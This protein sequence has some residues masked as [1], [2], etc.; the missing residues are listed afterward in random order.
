MFEHSPA[1]VNPQEFAKRASLY[2]VLM[3]KELVVQKQ[4]N[5]L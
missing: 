2:W 5:Q 1:E 4:G 3:L